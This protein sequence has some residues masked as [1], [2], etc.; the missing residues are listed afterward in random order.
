MRTT[1]GETAE[2]HLRVCRD[3]QMVDPLSIKV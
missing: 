3:V 2:W 1:Q